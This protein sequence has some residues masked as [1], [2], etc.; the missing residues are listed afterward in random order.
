MDKWNGWKRLKFMTCRNQ[1]LFPHRYRIR[2]P[3]RFLRFG[4]RLACGALAILLTACA[5][6]EEPEEKKP[7]PQGRPVIVG[8]VASIPPGN[9]FV[10]IQSYG[11]WTVADGTVL[12]T[13]GTEERAG[14]L[15]VT[16]EK[17]GQFAA[18]D[19]QSGD[20]HVGDAVLMLPAPRPGPAP[21]QEAPGAAPVEPAE[22][23]PTESDG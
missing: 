4:A 15:L 19:I 2:V 18:A 22:G 8:R 23:S 20:V 17:L 11:D 6:T 9:S 10:L 5:G 14:N 16:G 7:E 12:T 21:A 1:E 3:S 13:R